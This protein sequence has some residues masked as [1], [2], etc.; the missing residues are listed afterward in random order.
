MD[1]G[2]LW[3]GFAFDMDDP[4]TPGVYDTGFDVG[5][6]H[7]LVNV[8]GALQDF[9]CIS[10]MLRP[11]KTVLDSIVEDDWAAIATENIQMKYNNKEFVM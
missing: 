5:T 3:D 4:F 11:F 1:E 9:N 7:G 8:I 2:T 10:T 6:G